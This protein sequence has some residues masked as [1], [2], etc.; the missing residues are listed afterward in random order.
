VIYQPVSIEPRVGT[1][2]VIRNDFRYQSANQDAD[3]A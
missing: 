3:N 1:A 2:R